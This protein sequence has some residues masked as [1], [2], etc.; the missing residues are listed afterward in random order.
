MLLQSG[1]RCGPYVI[2]SLLGSGGMAAAPP[3]AR[4]ELLA[5][6]LP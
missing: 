1:D 5:C 2:R 6:C 3:I 4:R